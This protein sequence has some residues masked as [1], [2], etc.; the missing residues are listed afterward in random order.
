MRGEDSRNPSEFPRWLGSPPHARGR[1]LDP[2]RDPRSCRITP[3]CA[4]KTKNRRASS[5][6]S[7][8]SPP[9]ARG[10]LAFRRPLSIVVRIT[11]ACAG[12][13]RHSRGFSC[14]HADHPRMRGEDRLTCSEKST[15]SGS[16]PH[17]RGRPESRYSEVHMFRITPACAGKTS[18][19]AL[20]NSRYWDHPRMRGEDIRRSFFV[21]FADG[22]PPHARGRRVF[23]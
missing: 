7:N 2:L 10:R 16:P 6:R 20:S 22:S 15:P 5:R 23:T 21:V 4:G 12:K 3:A 14:W 18:R 17:A 11:P 1:R 13:T 8:G 9:H 19:V